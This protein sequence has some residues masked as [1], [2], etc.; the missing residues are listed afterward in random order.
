M[1][2]TNYVRFLIPVI[3]LGVLRTLDTSNPKHTNLVVGAYLLSQLMAVVALF[4]IRFRIASANDQTHV[5]GDLPE[6]PFSPTPVRPEGRRAEP[7]VTARDHDMSCWTRLFATRFIMP[8][9]VSMAMYR[10]GG[11]VVPLA[12]QALQVPLA[13]LQSEI[14]L[15]HLMRRP[16]TGALARPFPD[17]SS[18]GLFGALSG[19]GRPQTGA[20]RRNN[21][22]QDQQQGAGGIAGLVDSLK[23]S[24][25]A[26]A[27]PAKDK[28]RR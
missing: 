22:P 1:E 21:R 24:Q 20:A 17:P 16:A 15:I 13:V 6:D 23:A 12:I 5:V 11:Y 7:Y 25:A 19:A 28:K 3:S 4:A 18:Q 9:V 26:G 2:S 10:F 27:A 14:S 8:F